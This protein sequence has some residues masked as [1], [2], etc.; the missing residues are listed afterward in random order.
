MLVGIDSARARPRCQHRYFL[1]LAYPRARLL[2]SG[3]RVRP[4]SSAIT[5]PHVVHHRP[6]YRFAAE[7]VI[8]DAACRVRRVRESISWRRNRIG[9]AHRCRCRRLRSGSL[10]ASTS[11]RSSPISHL[12]LR[13]QVPR[14][15]SLKS[16]SRAFGSF[17]LRGSS[18]ITVSPMI[19]FRCFRVVTQRHNVHL[20]CRFHT[21]V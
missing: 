8:Q 11:P 16:R 14:A 20:V 9:A 10:F 1:G 12:P 3:P 13:E 21:A 19:R 15:F 4:D 17:A 6:C 5:T 2:S 7:L 18:N